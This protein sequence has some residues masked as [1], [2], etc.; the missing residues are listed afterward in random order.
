[1]SLLSVNIE[2]SQAIGKIVSQ[3]KFRPEFLQRDF[4]SIDLDDEIKASMYFYSVGICHQTYHLANP[5]LNLYGWDFLEYGFLQM[6]CKKPELLDAHFLIETDASEL[7]EY[8]KPF[9]AEDNKSENCTLDRLEE[10]VRLWKE[11]AAFLLKY[12]GSVKHFIDSSQNN[13]E[14][15]Y[16][17]LPQTEAY[18]D[19]LQ[20][21]SSFLMKLLEDAGYTDFSQSNDIIPI[22]DYHMQ[23]VLMRTGCI[24]IQ[25]RNLYRNLAERKK[26]T[27]DAEIREACIH[28]MRIIARESG[29]SIL[30]MNDVF[31]TMGRSCCNSNPLCM[32]HSCEK[33][34]C[35]LSLAVDIPKKH[36]CIF[37]DICKG[38]KNDN[39]RKLWQP[40]VETH[41]Y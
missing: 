17:N 20:K 25:D 14:Y 12:A 7:I 34:P 28:S 39:Y 37:E 35:T 4:I 13:P 38:A 31:Y 32:A 19:P 41:Y 40:L 36:K 23:R 24:E 6:A 30:K 18:S 8:I 29:L 5:K 3:L 33:D 21:K 2:Q 26:I 9:F 27:D 22:M 1:M 10:R 11:M 16:Q 15:F